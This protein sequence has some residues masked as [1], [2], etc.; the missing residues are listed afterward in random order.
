MNEEAQIDDL[1]HSIKKGRF[2][3]SLQLA[4][5]L[6]VGLG[7]LKFIFGSGMQWLFSSAWISY[8][9]IFAITYFVAWPVK[10]GRAKDEIGER[11][12]EDVVSSQGA[13]D[14]S[15]KLALLILIGL[16]GLAMF[17]SD[18]PS[19]REDQL[20]SA[21]LEMKVIPPSGEEDK[22]ITL[23][24]P[25]SYINEEG[26]Q[27]FGMSFSPESFIDEGIEGIDMS[28]SSQSFMNEGAD[29]FD[30]SNAS[31]LNLDEQSAKEIA[32]GISG[33]I[34]GKFDGEF[35]GELDM[36]LDEGFIEEVMSESVMLSAKLDDIGLKP[37]TG[38][39]AEYVD[40]EQISYKEHEISPRTNPDM[41][42]IEVDPRQIKI[43][44]DMIETVFNKMTRGQGSDMPAREE[45]GL[46]LRSARVKLPSTKIKG[47]VEVDEVQ[48]GVPTDPAMK[49]MFVACENKICMLRAN[50]EGASDVSIY[51]HPSR[52]DEWH[53]IYWKMDQLLKGFVQHPDE[54][55]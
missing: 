9:V 53:D 33:E 30:M 14:N 44:K 15:W 45:S 34:G 23:K 21:G 8:I 20:K 13:Q 37:I 12:A 51:F 40:G 24:I 32:E 10:L 17:E 29:E 50:V 7:I 26:P 25:E 5:A 49:N 54:E 52:L 4:V 48:M 16:I 27:D 41:V 38:D 18:D 43:D 22:E 28:A 46:S 55:Q 11:K 2:R 1:I 39:D 3:Y 42:A 31:P 47:F 35:D 19:E 6:L 36:D